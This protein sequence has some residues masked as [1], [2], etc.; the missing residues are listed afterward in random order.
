M[1]RVLHSFQPDIFLLEG[2]ISS[3]IVYFFIFNRVA[4]IESDPL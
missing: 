4:L 3:L 2:L 1:F